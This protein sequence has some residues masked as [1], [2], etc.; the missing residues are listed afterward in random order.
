LLRILAVRGTTKIHIGIQ[1]A[2]TAFFAVA[3]GIILKELHFMPALGALGFKNGSR[4]PITAVLSRAFHGFPPIN[5]I[6]WLGIMG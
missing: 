5:L 6:N 4:L 2:V 3:G 1:K